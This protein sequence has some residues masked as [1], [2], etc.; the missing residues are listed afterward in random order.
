M[1]EMS[2]RLDEKARRDEDDVRAADPEEGITSYQT[3][4]AW[5]E[6]QAEGDRIADPPQQEEWR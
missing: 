1:S 4:H 5:E 6:S 2:D 3:M